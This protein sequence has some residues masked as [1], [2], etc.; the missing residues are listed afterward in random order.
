MFCYK[1]K[2]T[3]LGLIN[4]KRPAKYFVSKTFRYYFAKWPCVDKMDYLYIALATN[5]FHQVV[6]LAN[7]LL[8]Y[9]SPG[10]CTLHM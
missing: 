8:P 6:L 3:L 2:N 7:V 10:Y 1:K 5:I 9:F 4:G